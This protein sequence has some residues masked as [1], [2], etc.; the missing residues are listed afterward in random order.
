MELTACRD[1][2]AEIDRL[3]RLLQRLRAFTGSYPMRI[4]EGTPPSNKHNKSA[5]TEKIALKIVDVEQQLEAARR[6]LADEQAELTAEFFRRL[7][8]TTAEVMS[9]RYTQ[10]Q[11]FK[12]I[13]AEMNYSP[14]MIFVHHKRGVEEFHKAADAGAAAAV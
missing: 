8:P 14:Q 5:P 4:Y 6:R 10:F 9:R 7:P 2:A 13:A 12:Q 11:R 1:T 3:E